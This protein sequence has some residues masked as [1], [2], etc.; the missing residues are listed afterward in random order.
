MKKKVLFVMPRLCYPLDTGGKIRT[1]NLLKGLSKDH[2][3]IVLS[4]MR[5]DEEEALKKVAELVKEIYTVDSPPIGFIYDSIRLGTSI[6]GGYPASVQR[7][8]SHKMGELV[9][10]VSKKVQIVHFD[11][12][13][14]AQYIENVKEGVFK[15]I[16][17]HNVE[18]IIARRLSISEKNPLLKM[19]YLQ[20]AFSMKLFEK[21]R[22]KLAN[23]VSCCSEED[24][25]RLKELSPSIRVEVIPNGVDLDYFSQ[26]VEPVDENHIVFTGSMDWLP[27]VEGAIWFYENVLPK[28]K[29]RIT[30]V[31][32]YIVGRAP[33]EQLKKLHSPPEFI[34]TGTVPDI[35][36]YYKNA[37]CLI[38]P[39]LSGGGT[40]LKILEAMAFGIPVVTTKVGGEG[41]DIVNEENVLIADTPQEMVEAIVR[42]KND[43]KLVEKLIREGKRLVQEKYGW[44]A[45]AKKLSTI[46][47][48][49]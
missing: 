49:I 30:P 42:L 44:E 22:I 37:L 20:Q 16:D 8:S 11:H 17:E 9:R 25:N 1:Y 45:I 5:K 33:L 46:Y 14:T 21:N 7:Y 6:L 10:S 41:I 15:N 27:N 24:K 29:L 34:V 2:E 48:E 26:D 39:L 18:W 4:F 38:V 40:R 13:H 31:R 47:S 12:I 36:P 43:K 35:R 23:M 28:L 3:V 19:I 32:V